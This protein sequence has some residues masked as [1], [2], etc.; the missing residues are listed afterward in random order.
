MHFL[1]AF[2]STFLL[3]HLQPNLRTKSNGDNSHERDND[4]I[5]D[6]KDFMANKNNG[7]KAKFAFVFLDCKSQY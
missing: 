5:K 6:F 7:Y 4:A 2:F 1:N 3:W